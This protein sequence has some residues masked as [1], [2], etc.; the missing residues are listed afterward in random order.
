MAARD[1]RR[2]YCVCPSTGRSG[3]V[4]SWVVTKEASGKLMEGCAATSSMSES[5]PNLVLAMLR[6]DQRAQEKLGNSIATENFPP[7]FD[8]PRTFVLLA[9]IAAP[10][11][12]PPPS[13]VAA[14]CPSLL[15]LLLLL[16]SHP[17]TLPIF[18][19]P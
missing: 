16:I 15:L 19:Y 14:A 18:P 11:S 5:V 2:K 6:K 4:H 1:V 12:L 17:S 3:T 8:T 10:L 9:T 13:P 7:G